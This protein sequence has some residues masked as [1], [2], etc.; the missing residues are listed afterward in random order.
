MPT[1]FDTTAGIGGATFDP[2]GDLDAQAREIAE[3]LARKLDS[4]PPTSMTLFPAEAS[5]S[6]AA[7]GRHRFW[8]MSMAM[9]MMR[10]IM[11]LATS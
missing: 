5:G 3:M 6:G 7:G 10:A 1:A 2:H 9:G 8:E 4:A 11:L